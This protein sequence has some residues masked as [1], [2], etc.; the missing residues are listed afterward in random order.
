MSFLETTNLD[1]VIMAGITDASKLVKR[2]Q[3]RVQGVMKVS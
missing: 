3:L 1:P 2:V